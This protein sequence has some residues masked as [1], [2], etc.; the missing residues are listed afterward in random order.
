MVSKLVQDI[1]SFIA[2]EDDRVRIIISHMRDGQMH[3]GIS[4]KT[5]NNISYLHLEWHFKLSNCINY[6]DIYYTVCSK[7]PIERQ[8]VIAAKCRRIWSKN[9]NPQTIPYSIFY[10]N[11]SFTAEGLLSLDEKECGLTCATFVLAT[12]KSC[13]INL[14]ETTNWPSRTDD[15]IWHNQIIRILELLNVD[16]THIENVKKEKGCS[17]FR[18]EEVAMSSTF[19]NIPETTDNIRNRGM[20]LRQF[21][22]N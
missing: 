9:S 3:C 6:S 19:E 10:E 16:Y 7:I 4:Y 5:D 8:K 17:R 18:P 1:D 20:L 2:K 13:G 21:L 11:G 22:I 15:A 14:I 12:F